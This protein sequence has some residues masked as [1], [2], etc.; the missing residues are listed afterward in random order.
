MKDKAMKLCTVVF[1]YEFFEFFTRF[2]VYKELL[3][4]M[5]FVKSTV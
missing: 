1:N 4:I 5:M 2:F 3:E